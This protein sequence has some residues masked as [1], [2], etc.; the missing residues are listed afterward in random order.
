MRK[1]MC[2]LLSCLLLLGCLVMSNTE[3]VAATP[4]PTPALTP[5]PTDTPVPPQPIEKHTVEEVITPTPTVP[6]TPSP[7]PSPT[8]TPT[9][10]PTPFTLVWMSDTQNYTRNDPE[11]FFAIRDWILDNRE[12]ENILFVAHTGDV[13]D[14]FSPFMWGNAAEALVPILEVLPG[15][16]VSGNHD[17][18]KSGSQYYFLQQPYAQMVQK[19]GQIFQDGSAAYVTFR[20]AGMDFLVFGVG[21]EVVCT[22]W[23]NEVISEH[24]D[25]VVITVLH[26]GLQETGAFTKETRAIFL[27][28][29]PGCPNFRLILCGHQRGSMTRTEWFD[30]DGNGEP[31]RSVTIMMYNFQDDRMKGKGFL[32]LLRFD[33]MSRNIEVSTYSPWFDQWGYEKATEEENHFVLENAW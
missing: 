12:K 29:M 23:M 21:Y 19:E 26:K 17:I 4:D 33:P 24:P 32:R 16:V 11:V 10:E 8:P 31:E 30:D 13:V 22:D 2:M 1:A 3:A 27:D 6:P 14:G 18:S 25:H 9:P 15:M 7:T 28:V 5:V 20:A